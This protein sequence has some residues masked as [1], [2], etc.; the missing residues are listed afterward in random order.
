MGDGKLDLLARE[1]VIAKQY[2]SQEAQLEGTAEEL[3]KRTL[4][5]EL[6]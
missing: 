1:K 4:E 3:R 5:E 6:E 2:P